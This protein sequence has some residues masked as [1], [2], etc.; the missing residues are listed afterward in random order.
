MD[1]ELQILPA[2]VFLLLYQEH[3]RLRQRPRW[4]CPVQ[5]CLRCS[6]VLET[7]VPCSA[8]LEAA[9][10]IAGTQLLAVLHGPA[11]L[12]LAVTSLAG[13]LLL[14]GLSWAAGLVLAVLSWAAGLVLAVL[15]WAAGLVLAVLSWAAGLVLKVA[16]WAA[17]LVLAVLSWAAGLV[18]EVASW[19]AGMM[20]V[21]SAVLLFPDF[22][23]FLW[24]FPTLEGVTA[25]STLPPGPLG[26]A[27]VA[28]VLPLSCQAL[29]NF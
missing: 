23:G 9:V 20:A 2:I 14:A 7:V 25:E 15:S 26:A 5:R 29:A 16:S 21:F 18:L 22:P 12:L 28:G 10:S 27:L 24:P 17:G 8:V 13:G 11:G 6:A 1:P 4:R 3:E 19:A